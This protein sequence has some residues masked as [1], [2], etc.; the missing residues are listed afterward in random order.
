VGDVIEEAEYNAA[1]LI[2][3][4]HFSP[5]KIINFLLPKYF[6]FNFETSALAL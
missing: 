1:F 5:L 4:D 2:I 3:S 6:Q